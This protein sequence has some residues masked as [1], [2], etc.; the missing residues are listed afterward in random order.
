M[1]SLDPSKR[2]SKDVPEK[3][4]D[5]ILEKEKDEDQIFKDEDQISKDEDQ[6]SKDEDQ[7]KKLP[8]NTNP[9]NFEEIKPKNKT[10]IGNY[11]DDVINI[12]HF[13]DDVISL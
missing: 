10:F 3:K 7:K 12:I 6:I 2:K 5:K 8:E 9:A 13:T 11:F 4:E 1:A